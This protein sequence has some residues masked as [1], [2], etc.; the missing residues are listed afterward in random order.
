MTHTRN[1]VIALPRS[2]SL[3]ARLRGEALAPPAE[4]EALAGIGVPRGLLRGDLVD[5]LVPAELRAWASGFPDTARGAAGA[6]L[7]G[8]TGTGKTLATVWLLRAL[9]RAGFVELGSGAPWRWLS[10]RFVTFADLCAAAESANLI[11]EAEV[12]RALLA[13]AR[14]AAVLVVD[15]WG[16]ISSRAA[17]RVAQLVAD[18]HAAGRCTLLTTNAKLAD[19][20]RAWPRVESRLCG[21][22]GRA[23]SV[24]CRDLRKRT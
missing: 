10:S 24:V 4:L 15:D 20:G 22:S 14:S 13:R 8:P 11:A 6:V 21:R 1:E 17:D 3:E 2:V 16:A 9:Y 12:A 19:F 5:E 7:Y 23:V 18:R